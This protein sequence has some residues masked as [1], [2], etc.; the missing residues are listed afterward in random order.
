MSAILGPVYAKQDYAGFLRR[1]VA[2]AVDIAL[3]YGSWVFFGVVARLLLPESWYA[4]E[5]TSQSLDLWYVFG[6]WPYGLLYMFGLRL[7]AGGTLGY[8]LVGIRYAYALGEKPP[9]LS[10]LFRSALAI[11]LLWV[12]C[13]DHLWIAFDE[14]RQ[15]W[16]DKVSG[17]YVV[18]RR[19]QPVGRVR[20]N[21]RMINFMMLSF[22]VW[23]L[24]E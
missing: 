24:A 22:P 11:F 15:A 5:P 16:H 21:R 7:T 23:E 1:T 8:R 13:L 17:F 3:V 18:K 14:R 12:F 9:I 19:A 10:I 20:M 4:D 6:L 2:L